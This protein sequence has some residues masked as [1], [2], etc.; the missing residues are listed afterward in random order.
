MGRKLGISIMSFT[1]RNMR[2][3]GCAVCEKK[4]CTQVMSKK[5]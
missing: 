5:T 4:K 3:G 1:L 2:R